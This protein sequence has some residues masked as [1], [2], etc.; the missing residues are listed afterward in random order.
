MTKIEEIIGPMIISSKMLTIRHLFLLKKSWH[1]DAVS[2]SRLNNSFILIL[3]TKIAIGFREH[4]DA[5]KDWFIHLKFAVTEIPILFLLTKVAECA[6][7]WDGQVC[8]RK[9]ETRGTEVWW[10]PPRFINENLQIQ[11]GG[12]TVVIANENSS[13][14]HICLFQ[15]LNWVHIMLCIYLYYAW[16]FAWCLCVGNTPWLRP[17]SVLIGI[18]F[19]MSVILCMINNSRFVYEIYRFL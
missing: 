11:V 18:N 4:R 13:F 8:E 9:C 12:T 19:S 16:Q 5:M 7:C 15:H 6:R 1:W 14:F 17:P 3:Q 2:L 10:S